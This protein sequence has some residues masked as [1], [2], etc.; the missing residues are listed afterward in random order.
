M[1]KKQEVVALSLTESEYIALAATCCQGIWV[2][3]IL[4]DCGI[5]MEDQ[6]AIHCDNISCIS[7]AKN[8]TL[9]GGTKQSDVKFHSICQLVANKEIEFVFYR[10]KDQIADGFTKSLDTQKQWKFKDDLGLFSLQ[11]KGRLFGV[12]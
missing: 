9:H 3:R 5:L 2:R 12:D 8:L 4:Q 10:S 6:I 7:I 11:S 1:S